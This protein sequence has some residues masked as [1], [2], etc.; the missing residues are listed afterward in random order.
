MGRRPTNSNSRQLRVRKP[1]PATR[2]DTIHAE[3]SEALTDEINAGRKRSGQRFYVFDGEYLA[4]VSEGYAYRFLVDVDYTLHE[5]TRVQLRVKR[6]DYD[7]V[8]LSFEPNTLIVAIAEHIGTRVPEAAVSV[9]LTYLLKALRDR[10]DEL[11]SA[12]GMEKATRILRSRGVESP[13]PA[14][15]PMA[16][17]ARLNAGQ[18]RAV[19]TVCEQPFAFIWGP[20]GTGKTTTLG[21]TVSVLLQQGYRV[22]VTAHSNRALDVA[23]ESVYENTHG[24]ELNDGDLFRVGYA[25]NMRSDVYEAVGAERVIARHPDTSKYVDQMGYAREKLRGL[26]AELNETRSQPKREAILE[27]IQETTTIIAALRHK[28]QE[29]EAQRSREARVLFCT[30][31]KYA[32]TEAIYG[33]TFDMVIVDEASMAV[34]PAIMLVTN[35]AQRGAAIYGDF[36]QLPPVVI[37]STDMARK[38]LATDIYTACRIKGAAVRDEHDAR[39]AMLEEQY[40]MHPDIADFCSELAYSGKLI[41]PP[42][43]AQATA[44]LRSHPPAPDVSLVGWHTR[45]FGFR[46]R[47]DNLAKSRFNIETALLSFSFA[48]HILR[49]GAFQSVGIATPYRAQARLYSAFLADCADDPD[50]RD[51][52]VASTVHRFQ[53]SESDVIIL[54]LVDGPPLDEIGIPL[55]GGPE[56]DLSMR[57]INVAVSRARAKVFVIGDLDHAENGVEPGGPL[58][59]LV[60][61]V[62]TPPLTDLA[63]WAPVRLSDDEVTWCGTQLGVETILRQDLRG[64]SDKLWVAWNGD[65][66]E[67]WFLPE[68]Q[69]AASR[70]VGVT[71][72][73]HSDHIERYVGSIRNMKTVWSRPPSHQFIR[74]DDSISWLMPIEPTD[75]Y[76][77]VR[78][79]GSRTAAI[80]PVSLGYAEETVEQGRAIY[81]RRCRDCGDDMAMKWNGRFAAWACRQ[82]HTAWATEEQ[83]F[84]YALV[85]G[86]VCPICTS[87]PRLMNST[88]G[89]FVGCTAYPACDWTMS[90][91]GFC[92]TAL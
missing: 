68:L 84:Q 30:L 22:L 37:A 47:R 72:F 66:S 88:S 33:Q 10:L 41:T 3:I 42:D 39:L 45:R 52:L 36:R 56:N 89:R 92:Q 20:P 73:G 83:T 21:A 18:R 81:G 44:R 71:V 50:I 24:L 25:V 2:L 9:D 5:E 70:K 69:D 76:K 35:A 61:S 87:R 7:G 27:E 15:A 82:G 32:I 55:R 85:A 6:D 11:H 1:A 12:D 8:V 34:V 46:T 51:R 31:S 62:Y 63:D 28:L 79:E 75:H 43:V 17:P 60:Q 64:A 13:A 58:R 86:M 91:S 53:G 77:A 57:L 67:M 80:L 65:R 40:R 38:W 23:A 54:D 16:T 4:S 74:V 48:R 59:S 14:T 26:M 29:L 19:Q 90:W 78:F 49:S